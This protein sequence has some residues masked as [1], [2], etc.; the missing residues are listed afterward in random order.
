MKARPLH[1]PGEGLPSASPPRSY[2][3]AGGETELVPNGLHMA[4]GGPLRDEQ[5][6]ADLT[7]GQALGHLLGNLP[8][9]TAQ[10][11]ITALKPVQ[12]HVPPYVLATVCRLRPRASVLGEDPPTPGARPGPGPRKAR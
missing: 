9:P 11:E 1:R 8:L 2:L 5:P 6:I 3:G 12:K 10:S 4:F 7:V